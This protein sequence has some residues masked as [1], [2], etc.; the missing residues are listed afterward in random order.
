MR[1]LTPADLVRH[2]VGRGLTPQEAWQLSL[3][4]WKALFADTGPGL[5]E[6]MEALMT[7]YPDAAMTEARTMTEAKTREVRQDGR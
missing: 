6:V 7:R 2:A 4:E 3:R 5:K 1:A